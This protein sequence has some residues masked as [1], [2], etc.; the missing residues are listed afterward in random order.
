MPHTMGTKAINLVCPICASPP[1]TRC[2]G[3]TPHG[4]FHLLRVSA[5]V[6]LSRST[7]EPLR[8]ELVNAKRNP[9]VRPQ[10]EIHQEQQYNHETDSEAD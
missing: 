2:T 4:A 1:G 3:T 7:N 6:K 10:V 5:A 8:K 9:G